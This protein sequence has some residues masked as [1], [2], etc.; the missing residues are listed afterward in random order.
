[1]QLRQLAAKPG[2]PRFT[3][4]VCRSLS[5]KKERIDKFKETED[6]QYIC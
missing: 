6:S 2:K 3:Y 1:M 5:K 4:S